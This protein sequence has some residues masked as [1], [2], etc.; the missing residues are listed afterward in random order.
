MSLCPL[1]KKFHIH[2]ILETL[3]PCCILTIYSHI[4]GRTTNSG[5]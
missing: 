3:F 5:I 1:F 2:V 4:P